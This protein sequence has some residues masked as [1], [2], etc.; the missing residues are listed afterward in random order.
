MPAATNAPKVIIRIPNAMI[1]PIS[2]GASEMGV[3][4]PG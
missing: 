1:R 4:Q 2:S 3:R